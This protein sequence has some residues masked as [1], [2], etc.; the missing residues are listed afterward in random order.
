MGKEE[1]LDRQPERLHEKR[2]EDRQLEASS[3]HAQ[4]V[5]GRILGEEFPQEHPVHHLID[6]IGRSPDQDGP[7][8]G[9][10]PPQERP[11]D[12]DGKPPQVLSQQYQHQGTPHG[13]TQKDAFHIDAHHPV[14]GQHADQQQVHRRRKGYA[15]EL[16]HRIAQRPVFQTQ[17]CKRDH[18]IGIESHDEHEIEQTPRL[19]PVIDGSGYLPEEQQPQ[20]HGHRRG[21]EQCRKSRIAYLF[22]VTGR[23]GRETEK[24][25]FHPIGE[26]HIEQSRPRVEH[27]DDGQVVRRNDQARPQRYQQV[28]EQPAEHRR[29]AIIRRLTGK[30]FYDSHLFFFP[31][32][33]RTGSFSPYI[34]RSHAFRQ[35]RFLHR[36][37]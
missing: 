31:V 15:R 14:V 30:T 1:R 20:H 33:A 23:I 19:R 32:L 18:R 29:D 13:I 2:N 5:F 36:F 17:A 35:A 26:Q 9:Q 24:R 16:D 22:P 3:V 28:I 4:G 27:M 34:P 12:P 6:H 21:G 11:V 37:T 25:R 10:H 7:A 8:V